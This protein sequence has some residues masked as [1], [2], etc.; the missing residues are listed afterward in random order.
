MRIVVSFSET[1]TRACLLQQ[2]FNDIADA[3]FMFH[4]P[5]GGG[6]PFVIGLQGLLY[7][8]RVDWFLL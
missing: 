2:S 7:R 5:T 1:V 8:W 4:S 6:H 3:V